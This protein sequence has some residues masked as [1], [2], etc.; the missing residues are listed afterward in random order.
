MRCGAAADEAGGHCLDELVEADDADNLV[1]YGRGETERR[2]TRRAAADGAALE[3]VPIEPGV[4]CLAT[5]VTFSPP[6]SIERSTSAIAA[7]EGPN[8]SRNVPGAR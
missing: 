7:G 8:L 6:A 1:R 2:G 5:P 3:A 4:E